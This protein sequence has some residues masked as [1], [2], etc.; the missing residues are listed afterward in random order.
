VLFLAEAFTR[1]AMMRTLGK[2]GFHQSYTYFTWRN[3]AEEL[4]GYL[5]DLAGPDAALMR[6]NFFANTPDILHEYLQYGGAPAFK[7]RAVLASMLAPTWGIYS[8]YELCE[9]VPLRPGSE[10]Y[11]DSEKYQYKL[12]DWAAAERDGLGIADFITRLN[13]I[14]KSHPA[15]HRLRNLRFHHVD[16]PEL[17]CFSKGVSTI[18]GEPVSDTVLVVVNLDPHQTREATVWLDLPVLGVNGEFTV[19]DELSGE[20]Y[21]WGHANYVRLDPVTRPAHIFSLT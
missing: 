19:T 8:G 20:S 9:N 6:P 2:I 3:T 11:L 10:E 15:L 13:E 5:T 14:R 12:R 1:P 16:Q 18:R 7:I 17:L 4:T 21:R